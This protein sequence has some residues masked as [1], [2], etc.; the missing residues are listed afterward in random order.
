MNETLINEAPC[1]PKLPPS[2]SVETLPAWTY[3]NAE[4]HALE[5]E[6]I[7]MRTWQVVAFFTCLWGHLPCPARQDR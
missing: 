7:F 4:F 2:I 5:K 1:P 3:D 6:Q